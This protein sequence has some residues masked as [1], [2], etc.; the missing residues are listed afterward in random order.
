M[1][2]DRFAHPLRPA[3][4]QTVRQKILY[5]AFPLPKYPCIARIS[6]PSLILAAG[7]IMAGLKTTL[8]A[9]H[10]MTFAGLF[11]PSLTAH[12]SPVETTVPAKKQ[13]AV[14]QLRIYEIFE[15]NKAAFH[16]RFRDHAMRIMTR[17]GFDIIAL[18]ETKTDQR[19][20]F[21]YL[22]KWPDAN[23]MR[24]G[25]EKL[26]ADQEWSAIKAKSAAEHGAMVGEIQEKVMTLTDYSLIPTGLPRP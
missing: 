4:S 3:A 16:E 19:T 26:M 22:I 7:S 8:L 14:Y 21:V 11:M 17:Y 18:W 6:G 13:D 9:F 23:V 15:T 25:W 20:E 12:A 24:Q 5:K 1:N 10:L 2:D